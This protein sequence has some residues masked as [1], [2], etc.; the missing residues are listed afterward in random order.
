MQDTT[1]NFNPQQSALFSSKSARLAS[2]LDNKETFEQFS[3][4]SGNQKS[5][6]SSWIKSYYRHQNLKLATALDQPEINQL[7]VVNKTIRNLRWCTSLALVEVTSSNQAAISKSSKSCKNPFCHI[8][9]R[10]K[11][12][13]LVN[14]LLAA[15]KDPENKSLFD[16]KYFYFLTLT[17]KHNAQTRSGN[18][19]PEFRKYQKQLMR[20]KLWKS[21][22]PFSQAQPLSGHV[23]SIEN[24]IS[25][26]LAKMK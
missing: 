17:V 8:C 10:R 16:G 2:V 4:E 3:S 21:Y 23:S 11:S 18:Y 12:N 20:S 19:L 15:I 22:F 7:E 26:R 9:Q 14:R 24:V 25:A 5:H 1:T 13:R 6:Q